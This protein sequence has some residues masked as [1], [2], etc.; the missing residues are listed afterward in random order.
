MADTML[1]QCWASASDAGPALTAW[2]SILLVESA[3]GAVIIHS[4][5][6]TWPDT[7]AKLMSPQMIFHIQ[8]ISTSKCLRR[9]Q[10]RGIFSRDIGDHRLRHWNTTRKT[11]LYTF[12]K[13]PV[14]KSNYWWAG[15]RSCWMSRQQQY[16]SAETYT[17]HTQHICIT[18]VQ[19][20]SN[21]EDVGP[22]L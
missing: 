9:R 3:W 19:C 18:F 8:P 10:L 7:W 6:L 2:F 16:A 13:A 1:C 20:R 15:Y 17:Q 21:V 12:E 22:T 5:A 4:A 14:F 11:Y